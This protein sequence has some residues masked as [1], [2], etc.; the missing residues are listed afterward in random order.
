[1]QQKQSKR[2]YERK[3][4]FIVINMYI[5]EKVTQI[6]DITLHQVTLETEEHKLKLV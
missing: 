1:M 2:C 5:K 4:I 6:N 3:A